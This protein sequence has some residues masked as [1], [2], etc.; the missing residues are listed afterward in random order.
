MKC[1]DGTGILEK[2]EKNTFQSIKYTV[3]GRKAIISASIPRLE[4]DED[5]GDYRQVYQHPSDLLRE[6]NNLLPSASFLR[7]AKVK[8][9]IDGVYA[10][11]EE[12]IASKGHRLSRPDF[13]SALLESVADPDARA[14]LMAARVLSNEASAGND[15]ALKERVAEYSQ[16]RHIMLPQGFYDWTPKL[17]RAYREIKAL[18][19]HDEKAEEIALKIRKI[20]D[21][22]AKL[23]TA[24]AALRQVYAKLTNPDVN[25]TALFPAA[26]IEDQVFFQLRSIETL[27]DLEGGLDKEL[28]EGVRT[29]RLD[30]TPKENSGLYTRQMFEIVP[31]VKRDTPEFKKY[32]PDKEYQKALD[33]EFVSQ[34]AATRE[35]HVGH[36][37][38]EDTMYASCGASAPEI[39]IRPEL[40]VEPLPTVYDRMAES[41]A[42]LREAIKTEFGEKFLDKKR[43]LRD[44][45][46]AKATIGEEFDSLSTLVE[47]FSALAKDSIHMEYDA[48][49]RARNA[50]KEAEYWL[51]HAKNDDDLKKSIA[52]F[53]P[54]IRTT[55]GTQ[56]IC[57]VVA[58]FTTTPLEAEYK[59]PPEV[60]FSHKT[61]SDE[62]HFGGMPLVNFCSAHYSLPK[63]IYCEFRVPADSIINSAML[64]EKMPGKCGLSSLEH[65]LR[66]AVMQG[67]GKK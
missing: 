66:S 42:F 18:D 31:L 27:S 43:I 4:Y 40:A 23:K 59:T 22:N 56:Q 6:H 29:G 44:G 65:V 67:A 48:T 54:I 35:T 10:A 5:S 13:V 16:K 7:I 47:G 51:K 60:S 62:M 1:G 50:R 36:T 19:M 55:D 14:Y 63:T 8:P 57:Y 58:G 9:F 39:E 25:D 64:R 3:D 45:S 49:G 52:L 12:E 24:R 53:V 30:Y 38:F 15:K 26:C 28:L 41:L 34:W 17:R 33:N 20:I 46:R 32:I 61:R 11:A 37:R 21:H 2:V